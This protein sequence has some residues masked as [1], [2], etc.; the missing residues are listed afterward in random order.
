MSKRLRKSRR[1]RIVFGVCGGIAEYF[2]VDSTVVRLIFIVA[3]VF[4]PRFLLIYLLMALI[5]PEGDKSPREFDEK[6]SK[7]FL[8]YILVALGLLLLF[9]GILLNSYV[10]GVL[11]LIVGV[12]YLLKIRPP[13]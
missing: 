5:M 11:L 4:E 13:R 2:G 8:A 6:K 12:A 10:L 9:K 1:D 3:M 7:E